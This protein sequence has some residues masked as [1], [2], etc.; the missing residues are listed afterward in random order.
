MAHWQRQLGAVASLCLLS[1]GSLPSHAATPAATD[2]SPELLAAYRVLDRLMAPASIE[3]PITLVVRPFRGAACPPLPAADPV[4]RTQ[5]AAA[6]QPASASAVCLSGFEMPPRLRQGFFVPFVASLQ[7]QVDPESDPKRPSA[8]IEGHTILLNA[9]G[10][11]LVRQGSAPGRR[12]GGEAAP[13]LPP[14]E[15]VAH[16]FL[17]SENANKERSLPTMGTK[18]ISSIL[19]Y[20]NNASLKS[21]AR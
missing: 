2:P 13:A 6:T 21:A 20:L 14:E 16:R 4:A 15:A 10:L 1:L 3:A 9:T 12:Q 8:A 11:E 19:K 5:V 7:R 18:T 17:R